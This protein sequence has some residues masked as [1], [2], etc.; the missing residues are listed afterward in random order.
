MSRVAAEPTRNPAAGKL[1]N[2]KEIPSPLHSSRFTI[3][4]HLA[5]VE[6]MGVVAMSR[7]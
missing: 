3:P 7:L 6:L 2:H 4:G 1:Q 5:R